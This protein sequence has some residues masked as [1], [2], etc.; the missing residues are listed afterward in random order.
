MVASPYRRT[1]IY[2]DVQEDVMMTMLRRGSS[3]EPTGG[4]YLEEEGNVIHGGDTASPCPL[5]AHEPD[6]SY[7]NAI[8]KESVSS[9]DAFRL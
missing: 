4:N 3:M 6:A 5:R 7:C 8:G 1:N 2:D 9:T